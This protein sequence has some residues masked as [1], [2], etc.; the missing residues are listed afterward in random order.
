MG[1]TPYSSF[2]YLLTAA[3]AVHL[4]GGVLAL[5]AG[6]FW[7]ESGFRNLTRRTAV[8]VA[9]IY[10]HFMG[11]LWLGLVLWFTVWR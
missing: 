11:V 9:A 5:A 4:A 1:T 8:K 10:W 6:C 2:F 7:P 3:H